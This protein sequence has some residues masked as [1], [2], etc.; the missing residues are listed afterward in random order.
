MGGA[1]AHGSPPTECDVR[2]L[3]E[4][5]FTKKLYGPNFAF[6]QLPSPLYNIPSSWHTEVHV[7]C[8]VCR[9]WVATLSFS[10]INRLGNETPR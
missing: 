5:L 9:H 2:T 1:R 8:H 10:R 4:E 7:A 3:Q 6:P